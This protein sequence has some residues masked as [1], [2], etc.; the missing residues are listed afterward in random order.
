M[1]WSENHVNQLPASAPIELDRE[2]RQ[3]ARIRTLLRA[4]QIRARR[5][6]KIKSKTYRRLLRKKEMKGM[7]ELISKLD[8]EDPEA[9]EQVRAEL[10]R[11]LSTVRLNRQR[12]AR[13]KWSQAAQRFGGAEIRAE[14]S[15]QAQA[16]ADEKRE[17]LRAIKGKTEG[18]SDDSAGSSSDGSSGDESDI[19]ARVKR[20]IKDK[21]VAAQT[22]TVDKGGLLGL[23][24]MR[25]AARRKESQTISEAQKFVDTLEGVESDDESSSS[26]SGS[27]NET[28]ENLVASLFAGPVE[29]T[30]PSKKQSA[31]KL[32]KPENSADAIPGWG[33]WI[34]EGVKQRAYKRPKVTETESKA[35]PQSAIVHMIPEETLREP[36]MKYQV[37]EIPYPYNSREEFEAATGHAIVPEWSSLSAHRDA[38][39]PR[40][41][42]RLGAVIPPIKLAKRLDSDKRARI[43]DA[44]DNRKKVNPTKARFL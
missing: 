17:L 7:A 2:R 10:E 3:M 19:V 8:K 39:K 31:F 13:M 34:G 41:S 5:L 44:W 15:K 24:F 37:K 25:D 12:Q 26:D 35:T 43:I 14:I 30:K 23:Q 21:V 42:A 33:S 18:E 9:A 36:L 1:N 11:K 6:K 20:S 29:E 27:Q 38:I 4:E 32:D 16:E 22:P 28:Q 40:V